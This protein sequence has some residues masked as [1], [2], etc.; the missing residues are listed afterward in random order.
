MLTFDED[1]HTY[2]W[3]GV[4]TESVTQVLQ[5]ADVIDYDKIPEQIREYALQ[6]GRIVHVVTELFDKDDLVWDSLDPVI[7]PY[8]QG[9]IKF[10]KDMGFKPL[11]IESKG[12]NKKFGYAGTLD[13][14]GT[15]RDGRMWLIDFKSGSCPKWV[16]LQTAAYHELDE[17]KEQYPK[18]ERYAL[19]LN[20]NGTYR[21][22]DPYLGVSDFAKFGYLL[23]ANRIKQ[24][25]AA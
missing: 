10:K 6:R 7:E 9:Y 23:I 18:V 15:V 4:V 14:V 21:L 13:R 20:N 3:N 2:Y 12:Y 8:L 1:T 22:S 11:L 16:G 19:Q 17:I 24:E 5:T 25:Y